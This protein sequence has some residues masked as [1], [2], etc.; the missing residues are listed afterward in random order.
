[1][2]GPTLLTNREL[3]WLDFNERVLEL[4]R[5]PQFP[6]LERLKFLAIF[7]SNLDEF[8]QVRV[9]G[10]KEQVDS[11]VRRR[12]A[13]GLNATEQLELIL[14]RVRELWSLVEQLYFDV[15]LPDLE[16]A[17]IRMVRWEDLDDADREHLDGFFERWVF[18]VLTPLG[19]DPSHPFPYISNLSLNLAVFVLD[20]VEGERRF[21]R[22][23]VPPSL[24]RY[25]S[26]PGDRFIPI[27]DVIAANLGQLFPG[28]VTGAPVMFRVTRNADL[29]LEEEEAEDLLEA[30]EI[31]VRRRRFGE[32]VR[33]DVADTM[34][35][36]M[37]RLLQRELDVRDEDTFLH[38][39]PVDLAGLFS[40]VDSD[41][42]DLLFEDF[43][44]V[45]PPELSDE[46]GRPVN[47]FK[48]LDRRDVLV[49][50]PYESFSA[51]VEELIHQ[52]SLDPHVVGIKQTLY[53]TSGDSSIVD[54]LIRAAEAGK[55][56]VALVE[57]KA[58]FDEANN[59]QW[60][61]RLERA[62]VHVVYGLVGL[63]THAK[64]MVIARAERNEI[65]L[66]CH[67]GTGNYNNRTARLYE[68]FGLL[69]A[70]REV[71][72][73]ANQL[74]NYLTGFGRQIDLEALSVAPDHL[75]RDLIELIR[76]ERSQPD[77]RV[78]MKMNSLVDPEIIQ[79]LYDASNDGVE[80]D[81][82]I[83]GIC[84]LRPGVAGLSENIRVRSIVGRY[85][86]HSRVFHFRHGSPT[87]GP[88]GGPLTLIGSADLMPRNLD[89]RVEALVPLRWPRIAERVLETLEI[90]LLD[91]VLAWTLDDQRWIPPAPGGTHETHVELQRRAEV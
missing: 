91:D 32:A 15:I 54:S 76:G 50:H 80:I 85:L 34:P 81:L 48:V 33:L 46:N 24:A 4:A 58:R 78:I 27:D 74:F 75:R 77:G 6:V 45:M 71:G 18:P 61:R 37:L 65:R 83:R 88:N 2:E 21:A 42:P 28:M 22:V 17:G 40:M 35:E 47:F 87:G 13:D 19:V 11:S 29:D 62:G 12:S 8:F 60:A 10:L 39:C 69:T 64:L 82:I 63:K 1:M 89:Q 7:S 5:H 41:R 49:H 72:S 52:A 43:K 67:I 9:A 68:D 84:C 3:S 51:S 25:V 79:E 66:Y 14:P 38:R 31:E 57:L 44:P 23:K 70:D 26:L 53:R 30:I 16:A 73:D 55:Q 86:E 36:D 20:P 90:C 59:I 56:V